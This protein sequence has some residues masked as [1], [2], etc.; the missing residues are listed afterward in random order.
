MTEKDVIV[1]GAGAAGLMCA[2]EA[3]KRGRSVLVLEHSDKA[4]KKILIS[5]GGRCN[6]TNRNV[7]SDNFISGNPHFSKSALAGYTPD[8]FISLVEKY[9]IPFH[10][11]KLGQLFCNTSSREILSLLKSECSKTNTEIFTG[12]N[13]NNISGTG[14]FKIETS[15]G[16]FNAV[17]VVTATGGIS[18]PQMGA[19]DL[20]YRIAEQYGLKLTDIKPALVPLTLNKEDCRTFGALSGISVDAEV[21]CS[22]I[23]FRENILF[24]HKGLSGPAILQIS[25]YWN[26]GEYIRINLLPENNLQELLLENSKS[27][28]ELINFISN[29]FPKR[30]AEIFCAKYFISKPLNQY[31]K[32]E[33]CNIAEMIHY[34]KILPSGTEG[35]DKAEVTLGG[36]D[37]NELSSKTMESKNVKGLYFIGEVVDVTGWLGGYNF[38]WAWSSG[39]AAGQFV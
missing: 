38:Q 10:E 6:F 1:I 28:I 16:S 31:S 29:F 2:A 19:T 17:S 3:G 36:I 35:F 7:S 27:R 8:D 39:F 5:G 14:P 12:C 26:S 20:G 18:I 22:G 23:S 11:K 4:G 9:K 24:T 34:W 33:L 21:S 30:F 25:S 13:V 32:K 15:A 37:T